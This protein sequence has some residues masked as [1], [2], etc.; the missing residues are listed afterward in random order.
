MG[1]S[2]HQ[3]TEQ[4]LSNIKSMFYEKVAKYKSDSN[5]SVLPTRSSFD[6]SVHAERNIKNMKRYRKVF[7][8]PVAAV[9]SLCIVTGAAASIGIID[10]TSVLQFL[11]LDRIN[12]LQ[13]VHRVSEDQGIRME[14]IGAVRDGDAAEVYASVS[15]LTSDR[16]DETLDVYDYR[17]SGGSASNAQTIHYDKASRTAIVRFITQGKG[18]SN[19]MTIRIN[20]LMSGAAREDGYSIPMDWNALL[21]NRD[22]SSYELLNQDQI[23]GLGGKIANEMDKNSFQVLRKDQTNISVPGVDWMHISNIGFINGKLHVQINPDNEMGGYNHG[24]FYFTDAQ[25]HK[26][27]IPEY[28]ISYGHY[29][30]DGVR[31]GGDYIEYVYDLTAVDAVD[32]LK[33]RGSFTNI[34]EVIQGKWETSFNLEQHNASKSGHVNLGRNAD[35]HVKVT[36]SPI[37][38]T[39]T[40]DD[41]SRIRME[42]LNI[43]LHLTD[44]TKRAARSGFIQLDNDLLKWISSETVPVKEVSYL[45]IDGK[46]VS[47]EE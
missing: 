42:D 4:N 44:G 34:G 8:I 18:S 28:S 5:V 33:L 14:V 23:S 20:T 2:K 41:L 27:D 36:L 38:I 24:F 29:M 35:T 39:L 7:Y 26:L 32:K 40:G 11:G 22:Q 47:L 31:Y 1:D 9:L 45:L 10:L 21:K 30:K 15:D 17:L 3:F 6:E 43:E 37:G 46:K 12:I 13:P 25:G 16:I 19:R